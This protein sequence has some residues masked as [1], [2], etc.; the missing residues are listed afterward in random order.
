MIIQKYIENVALV[1]NKKFD[2]RCFLLVANSYPYVT[3]FREGYAR[4]SLLD[5]D[6]NDKDL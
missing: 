2:L 3:L 4:V 5:Y 1:N 6:L